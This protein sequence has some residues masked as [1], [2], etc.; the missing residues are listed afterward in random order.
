MKVLFKTET[1]CLRLLLSEFS[2]PVSVRSIECQ[3][4]NTVSDFSFMAN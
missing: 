1:A 3:Y 4:E 2:K